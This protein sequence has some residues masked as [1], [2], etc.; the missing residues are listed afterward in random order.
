MKQ[1]KTEALQQIIKK[2]E[3]DVNFG[4][5]V[6]DTSDENNQFNI[7]CNSTNEAISSKYGNATN[8]FENLFKQGIQSIRIHGRKRNGTVNTAKGLK[9][10]WKES[11]VVPL[12]LNFD[13]KEP[14]AEQPVVTVMEEEPYAMRKS[15]KD[16]GLRGLSGVEIYRVH[17]YDRI[18]NAL[19]K[20][21]TKIDVLTAKVSE[22]EKVNLTNELLGVK[23]I[24]TT[25]SQAKM[26]EAGKEYAGPVLNFLT[27]LMNKNN[28]SPG[29]GNPQLSPIK[30]R[31]MKTDDEFLKELEPI[32]NLMDNQ[33]FL[34]KLNVLLVEFNT[35]V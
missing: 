18:Q 24:Q 6:V 15:I 19:V 26:L 2:L 33:D 7:L 22:L 25:E 23:K 3:T 21:E 16:K 9:I 5:T 11:N 13:S 32:A 20:A 8:Y 10:N 28:P 12:E 4:I 34:D 30:Q 1:D 29:L 31:F 35:A 27:G 17:D 14:T